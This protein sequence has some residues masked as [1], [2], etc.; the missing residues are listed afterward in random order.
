MI[1]TAV[2]SPDEK[3]RYL[4]SRMWDGTKPIVTFIMLNP[5]TAT[6]TV[7]DPTIE[8]CQRRAKMMGM[9]GLMVVNL[10]G[11]R[12]TDPEVLY[13]SDDPI[14]DENNSYILHAVK[15]SDMVVCGWGK[16]ATLGGRFDRAAIVMGM[17]RAAGRAPLALKLNKDGSPSHPLYIGYKVQPK[18]L[19]DL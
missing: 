5:S 7:N 18:P 16:H 12:S 13:K 3:Y 14:G 1:S 19:G 6:E 8:R 2:F 15:E 9:G 11:L 17:I 10:F 4:L